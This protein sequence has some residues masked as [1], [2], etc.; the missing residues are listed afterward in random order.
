MGRKDQLRGRTCPSP[1]RRIKTHPQI[2]QH[3]HRIPTAILNQC[4]RDDFQR[5]GDRLDGNALDTLHRTGELMQL[6]GDRHLGRSSS[7]AE[8]GV[9]DDVSGDGHGVGEVPVDLVEKV[10]GRTAEEDGA[11][12]RG[13]AG[14]EEGEVPKRGEKRYMK[15]R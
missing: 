7:R 8:R 3:S 13:G 2:R 15:R 5:L 6:N 1:R 9:K 11:G 4:P 12:F 14:G 10:F